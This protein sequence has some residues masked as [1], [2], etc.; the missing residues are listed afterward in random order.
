M[1]GSSCW[2]FT[3]AETDTRLIRSVG[4]QLQ[5]WQHELTA[6]NCQRRGLH[7]GRWPQFWADV[8]ARKCADRGQTAEGG[9]SNYRLA[10][11]EGWRWQAGPQHRR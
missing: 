1:A 7:L 10:W 8:H 4:P 9:C 2:Q 11:G 6:D 5:Q 3:G